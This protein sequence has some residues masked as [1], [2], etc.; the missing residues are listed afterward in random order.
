MAGEGG[1]GGTG[2]AA[3]FELTSPVLMSD[4]GCAPDMQASCGDFPEASLHVPLG[5]QNESPELNWGSQPP[6]TMSYAIV[7][8][9]LTFNNTHW[10]MWNIPAGTVTL[11]TGLPTGAMP[12]MPTGSSQASFVDGEGY[13]GPGVSGNVYEF[14]VYALN[15]ATFSPANPNEQNAVRGELENDQDGVVIDSS[16]L[17]GKAP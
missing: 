17:R 1:S 15:V 13:V 7:L 2:G 11:P 10:A 4:A 3:A 9:D 12:A 6:G 8:H 5:G 14:K 16:T